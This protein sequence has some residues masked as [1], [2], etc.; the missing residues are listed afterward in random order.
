MFRPCGIFDFFEGNCF[1]RVV[2]LTFLRELFRPCGIFDF[3]EGNC[4]DRVVY[5]TF[6]RGTVTTVWYI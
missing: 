6:L 5:L 4:F 1:D 3:F 2:Y